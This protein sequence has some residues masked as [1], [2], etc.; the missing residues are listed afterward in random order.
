MSPPRT[1]RLPRD[2][3]P[4]GPAGLPGRQRRARSRVGGAAVSPDSSRSPGSARPA[5]QVITLGSKG[6][7]SSSHA[8]QMQQ[9]VTAVRFVDGCIYVDTG[10]LMLCRPRPRRPADR[11]TDGTQPGPPPDSRKGRRRGSGQAERGTGRAGLGST[12]VLATAG[13]SVQH[14]GPL[15]PVA[16][17]GN[18][19][20][21]SENGGSRQGG[22][23][24]RGARSSGPGRRVPAGR[25]SAQQPG[26]EC[27]AAA[28]GWPL[29][30]L[31]S[32][33][34]TGG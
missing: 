21:D 29:G 25:D 10:P 13:P 4:P 14:R 32:L 26:C 7:S 16:T 23:S 30:L 17:G 24:P 11:Q 34:P 9:V 12:A 27:G 15:A 31:R 1:G 18:G 3:W 33:I 22:C 19:W 20:R 28:G 8:L 2:R 5:S 6:A